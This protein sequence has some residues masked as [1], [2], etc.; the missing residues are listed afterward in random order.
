M[1][2][3]VVCGG[4]DTSYLEEGGCLVCEDAKKL[5]HVRED[6]EIGLKD[7][8]QQA[9]RLVKTNMERLEAKMGG[10]KRKSYDDKHARE[11]NAMA[12]SLSS[13]MR[14]ARALEKEQATRA[15][16]LS[17]EEKQNVVLEWFLSLPTEHQREMLQRFTREHNE[18]TRQT[19]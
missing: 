18:R 3:V 2:R 9:I 1:N 8:T 14:E 11:A 7:A 19:G 13:I 10:R 16:Q 15:S 17:Y 6:E 12:R 4:C 5:A